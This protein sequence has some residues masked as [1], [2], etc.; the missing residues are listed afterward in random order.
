MLASASA[1]ERGSLKIDGGVPEDLLDCFSLPGWVQLVLG[2]C[3]QG[4]IAFG[5][6]NL[7]LLP[8]GGSCV[9]D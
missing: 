7:C 3:V 8:K 1:L 6:P 9:G 2:S 5:A 4:E